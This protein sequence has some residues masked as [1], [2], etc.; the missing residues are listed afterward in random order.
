MRVVIATL[1]L[2]CSA[3]SH[4]GRRKNNEDAVYW[5][6]RLAAQWSRS[7]ATSCPWNW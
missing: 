4:I 6:P 5:S 2:E 1:S 7:H 3:R